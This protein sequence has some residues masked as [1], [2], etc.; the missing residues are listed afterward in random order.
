MK[1]YTGSVYIGVVGPDNA[2]E[3][4]RDS[5]DKIIHRPGDYGPIYHRA[6]K[7]YEARQSHLNKFYNDA[8]HEFLFLIDRDMV[9]P[10][11]ALERLRNHKLPFVTG[12]Y[13]RRRYEPIYPVWY[14]LPVKGE[15]LMEPFSDIPE[16]GK[17]YP[18]G[19]S[20]WGCMLIHRDVITATKAILKGEWEIIEDDMD[21][22]PYD[23]PKVIGAIRGLRNLLEEKPKASTTWPALEHHV[24]TLEKE[25]RILSGVNETTGSDIRYTFFAREAGFTLMGDADVRCGHMM[26]YPLSAEDWE[27][28]P[29]EVVGQIQTGLKKV[30][31]EARRRASHIRKSIREGIQP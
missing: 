24:Q 30:T 15:W 12:F 21:I 31:L 4:C 5:I 14:K 19:A 22:W 25:I 6:T 29:H 20:G 18:L 16:R 10:Q 3:E 2:N 26:D 27:Q 23:L 1:E 11:D 8:K 28:M 7:G 9:I 17:L 13:M